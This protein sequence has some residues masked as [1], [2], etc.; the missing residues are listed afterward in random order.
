MILN[1]YIKY[2]SYK[3]NSLLLNGQRCAV[4]ALYNITRQKEAAEEKTRLMEEMNH[5]I[6]N[7][8]SLVSSLIALKQD[9]VGTDTDLSDI[10][11]QVN[12]IMLIH[13]KLSH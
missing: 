7:N 11:T 2:Y 1:K 5:R 6:K 8:L 13:E 9:E 4:L 3:V 12:A 10:R